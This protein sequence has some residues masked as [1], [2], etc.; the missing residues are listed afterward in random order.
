VAGHRRPE[1][2]TIG[3]WDVA[4]GQRRDDLV[5]HDGPV[6]QIAIAPDGT[7]LAATGHLD[8]HLWDVATGR[9][10]AKLTGHGHGHGRDGGRVELID[11]FGSPGDRGRD[12]Q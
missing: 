2:G 11:G 12:R 6:T 3:I 10:R 4:T 1:D 5:Q 8:I 7:W 9:H